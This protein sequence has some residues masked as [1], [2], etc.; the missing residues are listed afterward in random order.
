M[1]TLE[2]TIDRLAHTGEGIGVHQG[3]SVFV[4]GAFPGERVRADVTAGKVLRGVLT[5]VLAP[6]PGRRP[7]A[8]PLSSRCGGCDWLELAEGAQ[9]EAKQAMVVSALE[10]LG[11]IAPGAYRL[12]PGVVGARTMGYRRRAVLH[13]AEGKLGFF[14][15]RSHEPVRGGPLP[16]AHRTAGVAAWPAGDGPRR[17]AE[18]P[19]GGAPARVRREGGGGA[20]C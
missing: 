9:R 16:G 17:R 4:E 18:G 2:L 8:C 14:G 5:E 10:H 12:L 13:P 6:H 1:P 20:A 11:G 15:R 19:G 3:R 7:S